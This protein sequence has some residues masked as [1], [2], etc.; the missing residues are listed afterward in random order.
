MDARLQRLLELDEEE[1]V[2]KALEEKAQREI[3]LAQMEDFPN[4]KFTT[5][6]GQ[7]LD[8]MVESIKENGIIEPIV[9]W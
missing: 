9:L 4:H 2:E 7:R 5:Y 3:P 6:E 8:D 1:E